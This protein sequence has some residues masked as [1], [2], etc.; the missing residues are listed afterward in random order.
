MDD[1]AKSY[2]FDSELSEFSRVIE[3]SPV[4]LE[5]ILKNNTLK[6]R[7]HQLYAKALLLYFR[8]DAKNLE[9]ALSD[10]EGHPDIYA[11]TKLRFAVCTGNLKRQIIH[12][13]RDRLP[14]DHWAAEALFVI[15]YAYGEMEDWFMSESFYRR[16]NESL[17]EINC[18]RKALKA[19]Q[20]LVATNTSIDKTRRNIDDYLLIAKKA[21]QLKEYGAAS[22]AY[23]NIAREFQVLGLMSLAQRYSVR[24]MALSRHERQSLQHY[25]VCLNRAHICLDLNRLTEFFALIEYCKN[26]SFREING[27]IEVL[28]AIA[29]KKSSSQFRLNKG[30]RLL[31]EWKFRI[32]SAKKQSRISLGKLERKLL[33]LLS[34]K[35]C[36]KVEIL[37]HLYGSRLDLVTKDERFK[38]LVKSLRKKVP[39]LILFDKNKY[40]FTL[41]NFLKDHL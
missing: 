27:G 17:K 12:D 41:Q 38:S 22:M 32:K 10:L 3:A 39:D 26:T 4:E 5:G 2:D 31:D 34:H 13:L 30:S 16:A 21:V 20:N 28:L 40:G 11:I 35:A 15:A 23:A 14:K 24:A 6:H 1:M 36:S 33:I 19:L 25:L 9:F 18:Q 7:H 8:R 29:T 37:D